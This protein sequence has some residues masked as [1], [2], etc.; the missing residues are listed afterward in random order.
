MAMFHFRLKSDKKPDGNRISANQHL[1][2][3]QRE[4]RFSNIDY[5]HENIATDKT[6]AASHLDYINR[7]N[8]FEQR[9]GCIFHSHHLPKWADDN[10][11]KFFQAAD[12]YE[13][14]GNRRYMEIEFALPNEL[15]S[16]AQ[17]RQIIEAFIAKHLIDHYYAYAI[18]EKIGS[19]SDGQR[20][21]HVHIMFSE[22]LIDDV[23][24]MKER[25]PKDFFKYPARKKKDG[26]QPTF[27]EKLNRGAPKARKWAEKAFLSILRAD[28]AHI[29]NEVLAKNGFSIRVDH[30]SLQAQKEEA[31]R[32]SDFFLARLFN[33]VPEKYIG[34][35]T[36]KNND[37][38]QLANLKEFRAL[39]QQH[40]DTVLR[41]DSLAK[42]LAELETKDAVQIA[43]VK[44]KKLLDSDEFAEQ[45]FESTDL[46]TLRSNLFNAIAE[47]NKW[48]RVIIS[49]HDAQEQAKLEYMTKAEREIWQNH[50]A[51]VAQIHN[52][53]KFLH[54]L[55]QSKNSQADALKAYDDII[56]G[57]K[58]KIIALNSSVGLMEKSI[59]DINHKL[60]S[61]NCK[62]NI[63]LVTHTILQDNSFARKKL[64]QACDILDLA[65][66]EL[67]N[68]IF[69]KT[70]SNEKKEIFKTSEVYDIIR[71][72]YFGLK[73]EYE[74]TLNLKFDLQQ[75]I[76]SP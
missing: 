46:Q 24:K 3:I 20:H 29:Q 59:A 14:C 25:S 76:I 72:Q 50:S 65:V 13:G 48:K 57:V 11:K 54:S 52:L 9:E 73:K 17:Y 42:E 47:V 66:D 43:S 18:H 61:H 63:L 10:P 70:I 35:I 45:K 2:Y 55:R 69:D 74:K 39:R 40:F 58:K 68:A 34:M 75:K 1:Q 49:Q 4:G 53:E 30:R 64:K 56:A 15:T 7:T 62:K 12:K 71:R 33:R 31:E 41:L 38:P 67:R 6:A 16:V 22:R 19:L 44:A 51:N 32:T 21:P 37:D 26:S 23:E 60:E 36:C 8:G 5:S 27:D 28:F